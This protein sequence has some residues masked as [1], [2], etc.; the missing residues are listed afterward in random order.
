[1]AVDPAG[2]I[3]DST[4]EF[5]AEIAPAKRWHCHGTDGGLRG[6]WAAN[7]RGMRL[8]IIMSWFLGFLRNLRILRISRVAAKLFAG[9]VPVTSPGI[10]HSLMSNPPRLGRTRST[11]THAIQPLLRVSLR[12]LARQILLCPH[13]TT[14]I[15]HTPMATTESSP[16]LQRTGSS[17]TAN[18]FAAQGPPPGTVGSFSATAASTPAGTPPP[19]QLANMDPRGPPP[20]IYTVSYRIFSKAKEWKL[21]YDRPSTRALR[22]SK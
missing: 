13:S 11:S 19:P 22:Y 14:L 5:R 4:V 7:K 6:D 20:T 9:V 18:S 3:E 2:V 15:C 17:V 10:P 21:I 8:R 12:A 16:T 1:M